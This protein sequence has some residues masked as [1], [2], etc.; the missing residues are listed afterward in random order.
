[1]NL[2]TPIGAL[3]KVGFYF[4]SALNKLGIFTIEDLLHHY[5]FRYDDFSQ[6]TTAI[7]TKV[8]ETVTLQ[9]EIWLI[10]N[11]FT[12]SRKVLTRAVFNDGTS[13]IEL[14]WFN[15]PWLTKS[16]SVGD[17]LQIS[18][19]V[20]KYKNKL[21]IVAPVWEKIGPVQQVTPSL[22]TGRLVPIYPETFGLTSKWLRQKIAEVLPKVEGEIE[23]Y[24][25]DEIRG[26]LS[27]LN[28]SLNKIHFP[29][30]Y[31]E[32]NQA[33]KRLSFDELFLIALATQKTRL[34]WKDKPTVKTLIFDEQKINEFIKSLP[35][36]L[37]QAQKKVI[38]EVIDDLNT[39]KPMNRLV[40]GEVGSGKTVVAAVIIYLMHTNNLQSLFMAPTEI[41]AFQ[42]HKTLTKLLEPF[43]ISVGIYTGSRKYTKNKESGIMNTEKKDQNS[44]FEIQN[45]LPNVI[46]GTHALLSEKLKTENVGLLI[47]DEQQRFGV[48]QRNL[49]RSKA[50]LPHFLTMTATPI[51][52]TIALTIYGDLDLSVI[53]ELPKLRKPIKTFVVPQ[54]K[55]NDAYKFIA[56]KIDEGDQA[57]IITP[58]IEQS[59]TIQSAKA[60]K[61]EFE[62]L[63]NKVFT[64]YKLGLLHGR[65][66]S[67]EKDEVLE[68]FR[69]GEID[70][71]VSTSVVEVGVDIP[72]ATI[73]VIE[74]SERFGLAQL[75]QLRGRVGRGTKESFCLLFTE[76]QSPMV[77]RRLKNMESISDGLKLAELDMKI[78]GAG[79]I[80]GVKQSGR[81]E[82]KIA[83]FSDVSLIEKTREAARK[84]LKDNPPLDKYP[85]LRLKLA[86][87]MA[88][89]SPD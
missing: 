13:A 38:T 52:R 75:H 82:L 45:S 16:I 18:G 79:Q 41:L 35:F 65:L 24:L 30:N 73:M 12:K 31:D 42:H 55:R 47:I 74:S 61:V 57:Y 88:E 49:L 83:D 3:P 1:M 85:G 72:N 32:V 8:G 70:I 87:I 19:K 26:D 63:K 58:L 51:P 2:S 7:D 43:G 71:L 66:K 76:D 89:A 78:R 44:E 86:K 36:E 9:G 39:K 5:P 62:R 48:A 27:L 56:K 77:T 67:K 81:L 10:Q 50:I 37:T 84:I 80:Y 25:P 11:V 29:Q 53:D 40:Q 69:K 4:K 20:S 59:E 68:S 17:R 6:T 22:N 23:D 46:V 15:S 34:S 28:E 14:T 21:S 64:K 54:V 33:R 60:A